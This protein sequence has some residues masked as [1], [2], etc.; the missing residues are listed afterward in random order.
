MATPGKPEDIS[1]YA[2]FVTY[3]VS[4]LNAKM[5]GQATRLLREHGG[6]SQ[7]QW[8]LLALIN[9]SSPVT[10]AALV[11][12]I[13]MD[14]GQFSRTLK[15]LIHNDMVKSKVDEN[16]QRRQVLSLTK[17]GLLR[18]KLAA[19]LMKERREALM[20]G[21]SKADR[22]AFFRVLDQL[23]NNLVEQEVTP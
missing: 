14:A 7:V 1:D 6:L 8:R 5:S 10:S 13:A 16:D 12:S 17:K 20:H 21:V 9:V 11:K 3:R 19:P 4:Q 2:G 23:E 18:Y 22:E 15:A